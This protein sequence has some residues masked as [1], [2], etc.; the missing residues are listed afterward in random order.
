[1]QPNR[2]LRAG[3]ALLPVILAAFLIAGRA[4]TQAT[5]PPA[6]PPGLE[7]IQHFVFIMQ[8]NRS[9]DHYFG[10]YPGAEGLPPG[11]CV[12]NPAGGP[13]VAPSHDTQLVNQGGAHNWAN[14]LNCIDGGLMDGFIAGSTQKPGDV[15]GWHDYRE[16]SNYW[17]YASLYVLQDR[18]F[19]SITSYSL[20]AHLYM[21]AAQSGGYIGTGQPQPLSYA[22]A[23]IT[24]LLGGGKID[25]RYYVNRGKT[26][27]AADGGVAN[28]DSDETTYTFWNPLPA[29]PAV[30]N[31]PTQFGRLTNATQFYT[32]AQNGKL[33]QVSWIIPN[34][35]LSEHPPGSIATGMNYVT[36]LV[37]AVMNSPEWNSTAIFIA[38]DDWGGFYDHVVPPKVDQYGLGIRVPGLVISPYAR[39]GYVDHKTYSFESWLKIV[40]ERFGVMP[41]T[42]RDNTANDMTDAF[43]FTEQP[44]PLMLMNVAGSAYPPT[45]QSLAHPAGTLVATNS[46][47]GT[48]A[49]A[50]ETIASIYGSGLAAEPLQAQSQPLPTTLGAVTV[51]LKDANG[52][53]FPAPLFYVSPNQVNWLVP[54]G[55]ASGA[56]TATLANGNATFTGTAMIASM[57]PGLYTAN[58]TGQ[59]PVAAQ[60][61]NGQTYSNTFQCSSAGNCTLTPIDVTSQPFVILYGTGIRGTAPGSNQANVSVKIG[62]IDAPVTFAGAQGGF[63]G[64][65]QVNVALPTALKGRGQLVVTVTVNG[66]ASNMGQLLFQ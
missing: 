16:L 32:D 9:F 48:Y 45:P 52:G 34:S 59:G 66:Q 22:F 25:W 11:V 8:E 43:D 64:L 50:P 2:I 37:N 20:P 4:P 3:L 53:V 30:K 61:T 23:E 54:K 6:A 31:D 10:T 39:Q 13:C 65:D 24:Q 1:M 28:V 35:D 15:M 62:N 27:G 33:P 41:M 14:A 42:G 29:F 7:K 36:G 12:R 17:N 18:L 55:A 47:Y 60:A 21:L 26:A 57:A 19:E 40:E 63:A 56:A 58:Q 46:T 38:W 49:L 44:R 51:T 5:P